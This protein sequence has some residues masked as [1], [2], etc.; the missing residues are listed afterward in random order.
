MAVEVAGDGVGEFPAESARSWFERRRASSDLTDPGSL[1][2]RKL[3]V[4]Q[5]GVSEA[6]SDEV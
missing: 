4:A 6:A 2:W 1:S 5:R 3:I